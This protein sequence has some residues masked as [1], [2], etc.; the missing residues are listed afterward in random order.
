MT[1]RQHQARGCIALC[2]LKSI[3]LLSGKLL[4]STIPREPWV[5][6]SLVLSSPAQSTGGCSLLSPMH[7]LTFNLSTTRGVFY[8][9]M[10]H[11]LLEQNPTSLGSTKPQTGRINS[12]CSYLTLAEVLWET[13]PRHSRTSHHLTSSWDLPFCSCGRTSES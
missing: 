1:E 7:Y 4:L 11:F 12:P 3:S 13:Q 9:L 6:L 8:A 2:A 10:L 5:P